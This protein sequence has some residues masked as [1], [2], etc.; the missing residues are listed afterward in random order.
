MTTP[1]AMRATD[2]ARTTF[3]EPFGV[4]ASMLSR[5]LD[6]MVGIT[7]DHADLYFEHGAQEE[8]LLRDGRV[9]QGAFSIKQGVGTRTIAGEKVAFA[10]SSD[11]TL[12]ALRTLVDANRSMIRMGQ[13]RSRGGIDLSPDDVAG[14][15]RAYTDQPGAG[16]LAPA[17]RVALL[18]TIEALARGADPRIAQVMAKLSITDS[19][20]LIAASDGIL[21]ADIRPLLEINLSVLAESG[22]RRANGSANLG[23]RFTLSTVTQADLAAMTQRAVAM[24][25]TL[26]DARPAPTGDMPVVLGPGFPGVLL[27][28]AVGHGLEADAHRRRSS[29]FAGMMG[30]VIAHPGVNVVDDGAVAHARGSLTI[31]DEGTAGQHNR[32]IEKGRLVGLM[33]DRMN[34]G[35]MNG[36]PTG[37]GRRQSYAHLPMPRM[38]NTYLE[39]GDRDPAEII[40]S[41]KNGLYAVQFG[42]G[43]VDITTGQFNFTATEA[44]LIEDGKVTAPVAGAT[45]IGMGHETLRHLSMV[46]NDL[47]LDAGVCGKAGQQLPVS[48]GQPTVRI[49]SMAIGGAR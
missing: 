19:L 32:L 41:V 8:W 43:T 11:L 1:A 3:L 45:L 15:P 20:V 10:Y 31:D 14:T 28:E 25:V 2:R 4:D 27:H 22:G 24:A 18:R 40:A 37:N 42:G 33:Q 47:A 30:E 38:T 46:G 36:R 16:S 6:D 39:A 5:L 49:D 17:E 21:R 9:A 13:D 12:P 35:L 34:A 23:G 29:V 44:Y 26:L 7:A 48:V